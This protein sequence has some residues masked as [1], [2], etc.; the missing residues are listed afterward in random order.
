MKIY[1]VVTLIHLNLEPSEICGCR[2]MV[3]KPSD[4]LK[5]RGYSLSRL[6]KAVWIQHELPVGAQSVC[7]SP[8]GVNSLLLVFSQHNMW[9]VSYRF[10]A[11][12]HFSRMFEQLV[13]TAQLSFP[14]ARVAFLS[15]YLFVWQ[16]CRWHSALVFFITLFNSARAHTHAH[17]HTRAQH[18]SLNSATQW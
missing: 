14:P 1:L 10:T 12:Y 16:L 8:L 17:T 2:V 6:D 4:A 9:T 13:L 15:V 3:S 11:Y 18:L 5:F 7:L